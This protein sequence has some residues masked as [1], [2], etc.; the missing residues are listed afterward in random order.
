M[1]T[2]RLVAVL[3]SPSSSRLGHPTRAVE[4]MPEEVKTFD[5][6]IDQS[7]LRRMQR[8]A[9]FSHS[10]LDQLQRASRLFSRA[11]GWHGLRL[12]EGRGEV[13]IMRPPLPS[14]SV[15][16]VPPRPGH[17]MV[18][19]VEIHVAQQWTEDRSL[20]SHR[21]RRPLIRAVQ[22]VRLQELLD[23]RQHRRGRMNG[24]AAS[25]SITSHQKSPR[26][27]VRPRRPSAIFSFR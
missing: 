13:A 22:D 2:T 3:A 21:S 19:R 23:Q 18:Q 24:A 26:R 12:C 11:T 4:V 9:V 6:C 14:Q 7:R 27:F 20:R 10:R 15:R 16:D 17:E 8:Q 25:R 1:S 5:S